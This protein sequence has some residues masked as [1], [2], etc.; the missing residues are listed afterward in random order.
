MNPSYNFSNYLS[1]MLLILNFRLDEFMIKKNNNY[2]T[3]VFIFSTPYKKL[4]NKMIEYTRINIRMGHTSEAELLNVLSKV[5]VK[6]GD[7]YHHYSD[8]EKHYEVLNVALDES[9]ESPV[10]IYRALYGERLTWAR[11]YDV[12]ISPVMSCDKLVPRFMRI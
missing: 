12:W 8:S 11:R 5:D 3:H 4:K 7:K 2:F 10:I 9:T 1:V 6:P